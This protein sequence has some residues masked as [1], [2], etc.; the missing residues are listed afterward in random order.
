MDL[1]ASTMPWSPEVSNERSQ[2]G[3][4]TPLRA[5]PRRRRL[6]PD[7]IVRKGIRFRTVLIER[8][9]YGEPV[10]AIHLSG[11]LICKN[12]EEADVVA[13][14]LAEHIA[15]TRAE[16]GCRSFDVNATSDPFVWDVEER[17]E[18]EPAFRA[19]QERVASS[20]WGQ[21]TV[22]IERRYSVQGLEH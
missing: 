16:V 4:K 11:Q 6:A 10:S 13:A 2:T 5:M 12:A 20:D 3:Q 17:F 21:R 15:L 8:N 14:N 7:A 9:L 22:G 18:N 1:A 19:H